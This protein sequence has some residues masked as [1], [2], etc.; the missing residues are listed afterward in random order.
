M[1]I[2]RFSKNSIFNVVALCGQCA[3]KFKWGRT[4]TDDELKKKI[5]LKNDYSG[6]V[7]IDVVL[8]GQLEHINFIESHFVKLKGALGAE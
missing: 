1:V 5:I 7:K 6:N 2:P 4:T 3:A 8:G